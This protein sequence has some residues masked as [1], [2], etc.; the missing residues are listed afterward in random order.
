MNNFT[1][2]PKTMKQFYTCKKSIFTI[3]FLLAS[4]F[5]FSQGQFG[6]KVAV[7]E[8]SGTTWYNTTSQACDG[9]G[10][11]NLSSANITASTTLYQ[12]DKIYLGGNVLTFWH[13]I[14]ILETIN[15]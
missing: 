12:G 7:L 9:A 10:T 1:Q 15:F 4:L 2:N 11:G 6:G 8:P 14:Y 3:V 13:Y 5:G